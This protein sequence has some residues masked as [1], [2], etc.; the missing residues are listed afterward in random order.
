MQLAEN[1]R[2]VLTLRTTTKEA[3]LEWFRNRAEEQD[4]FIEER[5]YLS[6]STEDI[7]EDRMRDV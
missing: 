1:E 6:G 3:A 7:A 5:G 4:R 2:V